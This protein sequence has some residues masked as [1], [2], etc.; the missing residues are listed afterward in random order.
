MTF[1]EAKNL[2]QFVDFVVVK[3]TGKK[4]M[5]RLVHIREAEKNDKEDYVLL[6]LDDDTW[7]THDEVEAA[8]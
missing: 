5:V 2:R 7:Y 1:D 3:V 8:I 6:K 4:L